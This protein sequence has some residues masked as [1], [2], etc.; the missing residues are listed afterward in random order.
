[1]ASPNVVNIIRVPGRLIANP[2]NLNTPPAYGGTQLGI[3]R[4]IEIRFD[5]QYY[6]VKAEEFGNVPVDVVYCGQSCYIK[7]YARGADAAFIAAL[8]PAAAQSDNPVSGTRAGTLMSTRG[9][10]LLF[11]P[12]DATNH[13]FFLIYKAVP[14]IPEDGYIPFTRSEEYAYPFAFR[15][16]PDSSGRVYAI[17]QGISL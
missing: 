4:D 1:M 14:T 3:H 2:A 12:L 17:G 10:K 11:A 9:I 13:P 5:A 8:W 7:G 6:P 15:G 16:I